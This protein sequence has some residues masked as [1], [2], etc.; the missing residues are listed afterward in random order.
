M[1][2]IPSPIVRN[3]SENEDGLTFT[4]SLSNVSIANAIRRTIL[5]EIDVCCI[6]SEFHESN[7]VSIEINT[8]RL[9]NEILKHRLS[10]IPVK[11]GV[12]DM[13]NFCRDNKLIID[14]H[15]D[16]QVMR[17]V[18]TEDFVVVNKIT[19]EPIPTSKQVFP[20]DDK[21]MDHILFS[22]LRPQISDTIPGE[23]LKLTAEFSISN[24]ACNA[25]YNVV[26][27]C[28]YSNTIDKIKGD[29]RWDEMKIGLIENKI[30]TDIIEFERKN[31]YLLD[32]QRYFLIDSY[33]FIINGIGIFD[34][35]QIVKL[36][37]Q[38]LIEKFTHLENIAENKDT[39]QLP[40]DLS[41]TTIPFCFDIT[42]MEGDY[43]MG[44]IVEYIMY[45]HYYLNKHITYSGFKQFHPHDKTI[46]IRI[47]F[48][49]LTSVIEVYQIVHQ[50]AICAKNLFIEIHKLF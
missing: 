22:R 41:E 39:V 18:T 4:L 30:S 37:C 24:A 31:F 13:E 14:C 6:L 27:K 29:E 3:I 23:A 17:Y 28:S 36:A 50:I 8:G 7:G 33:D 21:T 1:I 44:K 12:N 43:T 34:N 26:S 2:S 42:L 5:S 19:N 11:V 10:C 49:K 45:M 38:K 48:E 16:T 9:H 47:A 40:V 32:A 20:C 46:I 35:R 25:M 15:N